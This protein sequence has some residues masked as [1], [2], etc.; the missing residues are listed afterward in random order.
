MLSAQRRVG[1]PVRL[2]HL[3]M[4]SENDKKRKVRKKEEE[5]HHLFKAEGEINRQTNQAVWSKIVHQ[6]FS[7]LERS[8]L[9]ITERVYVSFK[10]N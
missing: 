1:G 2:S 7:V 6:K 3:P 9:C 5:R 4:V 10:R 8:Q